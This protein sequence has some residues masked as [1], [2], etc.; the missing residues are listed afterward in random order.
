[1]KK[2]N[3]LLRCERKIVSKRGFTL[4][5]LLI[6]IAIIGI[7]ASIVLVNLGSAGGKAN[8]TAF[9]SEAR[10][11]SAGLMVKCLTN[12]LDTPSFTNTPNTNWTAPDAGNQS[13]GPT[14]NKTF[15]AKATSRTDFVNTT[16]GG[17]D[18]YVSQRGVFYD[19]GCK[20]PFLSTNCP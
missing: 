8:R 4:V 14:G 11:A 13:C 10:G 15:C 7:L 20:T 2:N 12:T 6:V 3:P 18:V 19:P 9:L 17:C 5:E 1:M 16:A